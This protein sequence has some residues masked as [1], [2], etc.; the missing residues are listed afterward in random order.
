MRPW[1]AAVGWTP[2]GAQYSISRRHAA[3]PDRL[4]RIEQDM[5]RH[6]S[7]CLDAHGYAGD[8]ARRHDLLDEDVRLNASGLEV[9]LSRQ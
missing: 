1:P 5:F 6:F 2:S 3:A 8:L 7:A 4:G 9:W